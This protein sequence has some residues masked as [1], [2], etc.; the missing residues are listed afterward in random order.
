MPHV[1][2]G[3]LF[4]GEIPVTGPS[5]IPTNKGGSLGQGD[6]VLTGG[7]PNR[8]WPTIQIE[9]AGVLGVQAFIWNWI[10]TGSASAPVPRLELFHGSILTIQENSATDPN[11]GGTYPSGWS[12]P[13]YSFLLKAMGDPGRYL[14]NASSLSPTFL[15]NGGGT[16]GTFAPDENVL[17][18]IIAITGVG[19]VV[20]ITL[21]HAHGI[22]AGATETVWL[23]G[24]NPSGSVVPDPQLTAKHVATAHASDPTKLVITL[25]STWT[26]QA[27]ILPSGTVVRARYYIKGLSNP[28]GNV[29][30]IRLSE[31]L[32]QWVALTAFAKLYVGDVAGTGT[33]IN[34]AFLHTQT[35]MA[36]VNAITSST[37]VQATAPGT[38]QL[39]SGTWAVQPLAGETIQ[40][41]GGTNSGKRLR[42]T[43]STTTQIIGTAADGTAALVNESAGTSITIV[44]YGVIDVTLASPPNVSGWTTN[45]GFVFL[46]SPWHPVFWND[47]GGKFDLPRV[48]DTWA[49][50]DAAALSYFAAY[51]GGVFSGDTVEIAGVVVGMFGYSDS[52]AVSGTAKFSAVTQAFRFA[53]AETIVAIRERVAP[54]TSSGQLAADVPVVVANYGVDLEPHPSNPLLYKGGDQVQATLS[55][56]FQTRAAAGDAGAALVETAD[57]GHQINARTLSAGGAWTLGERLWDALRGLSTGAGTGTD[58]VANV[59]F[60]IGQSHAE[61]AINNLATSPFQPHGDPDFDSTWYD[62]TLTTVNRAR[63]CFILNAAA[64]AFQ[65]YAPVLNACTYTARFSSRWPTH[66]APQSGGIGVGNVGPESSLVL[67]L[68]Q[69]F[70]NVYVIKVAAGGASL[71]PVNTATTPTFDPGSSDLSEDILQLWATARTVLAAD[72]LVPH[73]RGVVFDQGEGDATEPYATNYQSAQLAWIDWFRDNIRT[74]GRSVAPAPIVLALVQTHDRTIFDVAACERIN[75]AKTA[76]AGLR[77]NVVVASMQGLPK[78]V[79]NVHDTWPAC[80]ARG[81]R[82]DDALGSLI[83]TD[84]FEVDAGASENP[85]LSPATDEDFSGFTSISSSSSSSGSGGSTSSGSSPSV[86]TESVDGGSIAAT[87]DPVEI[88]SDLLG[89]AQAIILLVDTAIANGLEFASYSVNGRT[90]TL[91]S[92]GEMLAVRAQYALI[93]QR[94]QGRGRTY[95]TF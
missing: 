67:E 77:P 28:S 37:A 74:E 95:A 65:E 38:L 54:L 27:G 1:R 86:G 7:D 43:S 10:G 60:L 59:V 19:A 79:Q 89:R 4:L 68:R 26:G 35:P 90:V 69:R 45:T 70:E 75:A 6:W 78:N 17:G 93:V 14:F 21:S 61:G 88:P 8:Y 51:P 71:Q 22:T 2:R 94:I 20:T 44:N 36:Y 40:V 32:P 53:M 25:P 92:L 48:I 66:L 11:N 55:I 42:V 63:K 64:G 73:L 62:V 9:Y 18:S 80:I 81:R 41:N 29:L 24:L 33:N 83:V 52:S 56:Q 5:G 49:L 87:G 58:R 57:L 50:V 30:R 76:C 85:R 91:R 72:G 16:V 84:G 15:L 47:C 13:E 12:G 39:T 46:R 23:Y 3:Y 82:Y 31:G 34:G